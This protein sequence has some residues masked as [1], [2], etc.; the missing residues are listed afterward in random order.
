MG[1]NWADLPPYVEHEDRRPY[2][3]WT[4]PTPPPLSPRA[5][6]WVTAIIVVAVLTFVGITRPE[7]LC[8]EDRAVCEAGGNQ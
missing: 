5:L 4:I 6:R 2:H 7:L 1:S 3:E 8:G